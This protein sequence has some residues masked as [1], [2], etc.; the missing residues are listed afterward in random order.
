MKFELSEEDLARI[1]MFL[2][3]IFES[4]ISFFATKTRSVETTASQYAQGLLLQQGRGNMSKYANNVL[5]SSARRF[6]YFISQSPWEYRPI[7]A[8][9]QRD[10]MGRIGD[11]RDG[12]IHIDETSFPKQ[13]DDSVG[14]KRQY[15][16]RLGKVDNCQVAV[17]LGYTKGSLRTLIDTELY[18]PEDWA[19]DQSRREKCGIPEDL[20]FKTK[21]E[22]ALELIRIARSNG[23]KFG[24]VG[25]DTFYGRQS[26][27]LNA[28]DSD[29]IVYMAD[30]PSD[31]R[32]WLNFPRVGIPE[33]KSSR[34]RIPTEP[35]VLD[36][37]PSPTEV[38]KI[39]DELD[40]S[41]WVH[42][43]V[44]DTERREL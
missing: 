18:I 35:R 37:E 36:D 8:Q 27:L 13:G 33:R 17:C 29:G 1:L 2:A 16:G 15:S 14:V 24:W 28:I 38:R 25:M 23:V 4:Y 30:I 10:V 6:Q 3:I 43:F 26:S 7:I 34:G 9:I 11:A 39:K 44:R 19:S 12:A 22:I 5:D 20:K 31:T 21:A 32:V 42:T 40:P 41:Q